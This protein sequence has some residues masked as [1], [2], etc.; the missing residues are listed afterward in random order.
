MFRNSLPG[1]IR[2][3]DGRV[4]SSRHTSLTAPATTD[5]AGTGMAEYVVFIVGVALIGL[6]GL[7]LLAAVSSS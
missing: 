5:E 1:F 3:R 4:A 2:V 7:L 6:G